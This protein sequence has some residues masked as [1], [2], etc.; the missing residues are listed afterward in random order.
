MHTWSQMVTPALRM[1]RSKSKQVCIKH[2]RRSSISWIFVSYTL[3]CTTPQISKCKAYDDPGPL[4]WCYMIH[5]MQF[6]AVILHFR[7]FDFSQGS[8]AT[9]IRSGGWSSY[10]HMC[11]SFLNLSVKTALK[12]VDFYLETRSYASAVLGVVILSVRPSVRPS[13][14]LSV[15]RVL[16][17]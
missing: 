9:L 15:T 16:C 10:Y 7:C 3:C 13:V 12:S 5:L 14:R 17:D 1:F 6:P 8:V 11:C 4:W 2:F